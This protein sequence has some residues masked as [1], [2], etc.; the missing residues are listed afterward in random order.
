MAPLAPWLL[1][2]RVQQES[3]RPVGQGEAQNRSG[4]GAISRIE[5]RH[6]R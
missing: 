6:S 5:G 4:L 3:P 2:L 1:Y